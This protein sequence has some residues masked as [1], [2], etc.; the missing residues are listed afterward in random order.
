MA[1]DLR[2]NICVSADDLATIDANAR[3]AGMS[4]S[5]FVAECCARDRKTFELAA[6]PGKT[7]EDAAARDGGTWPSE[8]KTAR[9]SVKLTGAEKLRI[10]GRARR[11]GKSMSRFVV[12]SALSDDVTFVEACDRAALAGLY[13]ELGRQGANLNQIAAKIGRIASIA[14]REDVSGELI[15]RL[16]REVTEDNERTRVCVNDA[17]RAVRRALVASAG[18]GGEEE[19]R[20]D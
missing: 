6:I 15:S 11:A 14:W 10:A 5:E 13:S 18:A 19:G 20:S 3:L 1:K 4:R 16:V 9:L 17:L 12:A 8:R 2:A 7:D